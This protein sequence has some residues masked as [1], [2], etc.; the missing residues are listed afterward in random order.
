MAT[1]ENSPKDA[2]SPGVLPIV[3]TAGLRRGASGFLYVYVL[4]IRERNFSSGIN[5]LI[6]VYRMFT[7]VYGSISL[8][9]GLRV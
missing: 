1:A 3:S 4:W 5:L 8:S 7:E 9:P 2:D 6:S